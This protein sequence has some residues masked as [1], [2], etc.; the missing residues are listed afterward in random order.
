MER[1]VPTTGEEPSSAR[2]VEFA[3]Y[4]SRKPSVIAEFLRLPA[5]LKEYVHFGGACRKIPR[6]EVGFLLECRESRACALCVQKHTGQYHHGKVASLLSVMLGHGYGQR[7]P[8]ILFGSDHTNNACKTFVLIEKTRLRL[9]P[10][11]PSGGARPRF[12][13]PNGHSPSGR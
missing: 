10:R 12:L 4:K 9:E 2:S 3:G 6:R 7:K 8:S 13:F 1:T 11:K 5:M